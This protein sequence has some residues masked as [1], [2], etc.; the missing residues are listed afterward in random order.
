MQRK[1][2]GNVV[3]GAELERQHLIDLLVLRRQ[4]D[5]RHRAELANFL[6]RLDAVEHG[7]HDVEHDEVGLLALRHRDRAA[8]VAG[9]DD[10]VA[11]A[12]QIEPQRLQDRGLVV[13]D[14]DFLIEVRAFD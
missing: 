5:D 11:A 7:Q 12:L 14:E 9:R 6:A 4:H 10:G 1:R 13:D 2:L 3:V 8:A